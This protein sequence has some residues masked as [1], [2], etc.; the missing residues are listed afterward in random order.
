MKCKFSDCF[1][2]P[3]PDCINDAVNPVVTY[4]PERLKA[5]RE[6]SRKR[7]LRSEAA[8][9]CTRCGKRPASNGYKT[10]IDCRLYMRRKAEEKHRRNGHLPRSMLDGDELCAVCGKNPPIKPYKVCEHCLKN[11]RKN[12]ALSAPRMQ[13]KYQNSFRKNIEI[14]WLDKNKKKKAE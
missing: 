13:E 5:Q 12:I 2:C 8:G 1:N 6:Y 3:Y 10:C 11:C 4:T 7:K 14:Q 9:L